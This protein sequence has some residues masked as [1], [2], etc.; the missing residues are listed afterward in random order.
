MAKKILMIED[1]Q[2]LQQILGDLLTSEGFEIAQAYDGEAGLVM[3]KS[4]NPDL[5]LLDLRLPR[6]NG[7]EVLKE[8]RADEN[9]GNTPVVVFTNL[10]S[11]V[12]IDRAL[13]AGATTYIVKANYELSDILAKIRSILNKY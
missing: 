6:K 3:A 12:D 8:L 7:F 4:E 5:I 13:E 11:A 1:E 9:L 2:A 10:E